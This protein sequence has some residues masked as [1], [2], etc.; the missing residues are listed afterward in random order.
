MMSEELHDSAALYV[1]GSLDAAEAAAF[2]SS[3]KGDAELRALVVE[4]REAAGAIALTAPEHTPSASLKQKVLRDIAAE[5]SG[6]LTNAT[7]GRRSLS[8]AWPWAIAAMF[9]LFSGFLVY[10]RAQLRREIAQVRDR[11]SLMQAN[12]VA[13]AP[14]NGAPAAAKATVA[15]EADRQTGVIRITGLPAAGTGKDYQLWA[16]DADHKDPVSAGLV[17]IDANGVAQVRFKPIAEARHVKA[18]AISLE[19]EGGVP[20]AEGPILL[21]GSTTG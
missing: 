7:E 11:D 14:A 20:K 18:F 3:L 21:V 4:L 12:L 5:K 17:H 1:L 9:L 13:L 6:D 16:V 15:W 19:R 2:E 8:T 10:D